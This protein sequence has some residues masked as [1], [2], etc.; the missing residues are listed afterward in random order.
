MTVPHSRL[1]G[2]FALFVAAAG[3]AGMAQLS[4]PEK[5]EL[6]GGNTGLAAQGF[7]FADLVQGVDAPIDAKE[8]PDADIA[9]VPPA[10]TL[11]P[12][13]EKVVVEAVQSAVQPPPPGAVP[14]LP[15]LEAEPIQSEKL[16]EPRQPETATAAPKPE[17]LEPLPD[18]KPEPKPRPKPTRVQKRGNNA[19]QNTLA[20]TQSGTAPKHSGQ[21]QT[22]PGTAKQQGNATADNYR[23]KVLRRVMRAKRQRVNI[24]GAALVRFTITGSGALGSARIAKSSG[25]SKLDNIALAQVR[26]AAPFPPPPKGIRPSYTVKIKGK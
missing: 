6:S 16:S 15:A 2:V 9:A 17:V 7:A 12:Q 18:A 20:G 26:R 11:S 10:T 25:S 4:V 23:G 8:L 1:I 24:R 19:E 3:H 5:A 22:S 21:A 14:I 13:V